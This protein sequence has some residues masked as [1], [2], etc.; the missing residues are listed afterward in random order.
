MKDSSQQTTNHARGFTIVELL[1][2][3]VVVGILAAITI[4]AFNGVRQRASDA[5]RKSDIANIAKAIQSY[6]VEKGDTMGSGSGCG[7]D[8]NGGGY[9]HKDY[10]NEGPWRSISQCLIDAKVLSS[11]LN[12]PNSANGC[13]V[14]GG[15]EHEC[16]HYMKYDC[17]GGLYLYANLESKPHSSIDT[18]QG[19]MTTLDSEYGMNYFL[20]VN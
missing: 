6:K 3:I 10:D 4:V 13:L 16:P 15:G 12:D 19:C 5:Q 8:G 9:Y 14:L 1:I 11:V 17:S 18:D 7:Q 2:V 20:R